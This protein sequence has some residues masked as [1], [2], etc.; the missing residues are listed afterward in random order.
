MRKYILMWSCDM[1]ILRFY[2]IK[3][4]WTTF[5]GYYNVE[6]GDHYMV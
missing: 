5:Y 1:T 6:Q 2:E 3:Y 4:G